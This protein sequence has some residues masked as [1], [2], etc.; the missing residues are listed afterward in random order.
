MNYQILNHDMDKWMFC[1]GCGTKI[2]R[3][4]RTRQS[5]KDL[6]SIVVYLPTCGC[7]TPRRIERFEGSETVV[8]LYV[9]DVI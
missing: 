1:R 2:Y 8:S 7:K 3:A 9:Q 6:R 5:E 4:E